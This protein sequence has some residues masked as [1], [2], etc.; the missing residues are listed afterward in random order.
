M[1][2]SAKKKLWLEYS[3]R[4]SPENREA[5]ILEYAHLVK[6]VAGRMSMYFGSN[7]EFNDLVGYGI[8][9]L[10]DAIDKFDPGKE[11]KFETYASLRI[12]G[13]I[14]DQIRKL[15]WVPRM[16][17]QRQRQLEDVGRQL[18]AENGASPTDAV[19]GQRLGISAQEVAQ[20]SSQVRSSNMVSLNE[21]IDAGGDVTCDYSFNHNENQVSPEELAQRSELKEQIKKTLSTLTQNERSVV[22]LYY[23]EELTVKEISRV[24]EVSES[25]VSQ[26]HSKALQ[27]L[28]IRLDS[29]VNG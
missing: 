25:R 17:R 23:Y 5:I 24:L 14:L 11:V 3:L 15:D 26:L 8:F 13:S 9:G 29:Y 16:V 28:H 10:I 19:I 7:V 2:E 27:K 21:Y 18:E 1:D 20:W 12:R 22:E 6:L 4:P